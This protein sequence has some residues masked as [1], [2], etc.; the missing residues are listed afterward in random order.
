MRAVLLMIAN[1]VSGK[2]VGCE[3]W[4]RWNQRTVA[5]NS[6]ALAKSRLCSSDG[7]AIR[8]IPPKSNHGIGGCGKMNRVTSDSCFGWTADAGQRL[9]RRT[10]QS[11]P[12]R[13]P[14]CPGD[15]RHRLARYHAIDEE[16]NDTS[17]W[18]GSHVRSSETADR[19]AVALT[20]V[21]AVMPGNAESWGIVRPSPVREP[22]RGGIAAHG[23]ANRVCCLNAR[24]CARGSGYGTRASARCRAGSVPLRTVPAPQRSRSGRSPTREPRCCSHRSPPRNRSGR[25]PVSP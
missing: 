24:D 11:R 7:V 23:S 10:A 25:I 21:Q 15:L 17:G 13:H 6:S 2:I 14:A 5:G 19:L 22:V 12:T 20:S 1:S 18:P 4:G 9:P 16:G 3:R 8:A